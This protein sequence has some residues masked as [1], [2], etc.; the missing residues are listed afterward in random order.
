MNITFFVPNNI[1]LIESF[2]ITQIIDFIDNGHKVKI[3]SFGKLK[4]YTQ[5][6][7]TNYPQ[8]SETISLSPPTNDWKKIKEIFK[9]F[10]Q[11]EQ[12]G[13]VLKSLNFRKFP[14]LS[15]KLYL[16][17]YSLK[18]EK[19]EIGEF[20]ICHFGHIGNILAQLREIGIINFQ[21]ITFFHGFDFNVLVKKFGKD[22]YKFLI[23][24]NLPIFAVSISLKEKLIDIGFSEKQTQVHSMSVDPTFL[25]SEIEKNKFEKIETLRIIT[26]ARLEKIKGI[27][28]SLMAFSKVL[29]DGILAEYWIVGDGKNRESLEEL[30]VD[31]KISKNVKFLGMQNKS[32]IKLLLDKTHIFILPSIVSEGGSPLV[33]QEAMARG[34]Y[35]IGTNKGGIVELIKNTGKL[36]EPENSDEIYKAIKEFLQYSSIKIMDEK[37]IPGRKIIEKEY[38][39][40][41][42]NKKL[43]NLSRRENLL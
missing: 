17:Y 18:F 2:M 42:L 41:L 22:F 9:M 28:F 33:L 4:N 19:L 38:E 37:I 43:L 6:T 39:I 10:Y 3:F 13:K 36:I 12:K 7:E 15:K 40:S 5:F 31:L 1:V 35:C 8:F 14:F 16:L 20:V 21:F 27:R 25:A 34:N 23:K 11:S 24:S 30:A 26:V 29:E 32:Q